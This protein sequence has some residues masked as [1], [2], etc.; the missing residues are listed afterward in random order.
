MKK[1]EIVVHEF[2]DDGK[3]LSVVCTHTLFTSEDVDAGTLEP[4]FEELGLAGCENCGVLFSEYTR[5]C[6]ECCYSHKPERELDL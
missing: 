5:I 2:E 1:Y 6:P 4:A 3:T